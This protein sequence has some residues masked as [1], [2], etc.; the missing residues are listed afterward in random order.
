MSISILLKRYILLRL[1]YLLSIY[2]NPVD[3]LPP[4]HPPPP[5]MV[6]TEPT[7]VLVRPIGGAVIIYVV[8]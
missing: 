7:T 1:V 5:P 2:R 6:S 3:P 8:M 4:P